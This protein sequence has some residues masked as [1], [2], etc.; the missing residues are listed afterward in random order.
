MQSIDAIG[1]LLPHP[2]TLTRT[3][4]HS[5]SQYKRCNQEKLLPIALTLF[6]K[7]NIDADL[8]DTV[9]KRARDAAGML[10]NCKLN[11]QSMKNTDIPP[12]PDDL[13]Y[14]SHCPENFV[15]M[16]YHQIPVFVTL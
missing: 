12:M 5:L 7:V 16:P 3:H 14:S 13:L 10:H 6:L 9:G 4:L 11:L 2:C 1:G 8:S 15:K